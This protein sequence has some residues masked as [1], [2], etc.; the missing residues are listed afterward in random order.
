MTKAGLQ[1]MWEKFDHQTFDTCPRYYCHDQPLLPLG[2]SS[3]PGE[4]A[5]RVYCLNCQ[6]LYLPQSAKH[7]KMD[8]VA[9]GP[10]F[11]HFFVR[12]VLYSNGNKALENRKGPH[13]WKVYVP[14]IYGFRIYREGKEVKEEGI[15]E[16]RPIDFK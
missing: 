8:G 9:F 13:D 16:E 3:L 7:A 5:V 6:D 4:A 12:T 14:R 10:S 1:A 11:A 15:R 2:P